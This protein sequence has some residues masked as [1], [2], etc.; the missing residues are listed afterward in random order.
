MAN[1]SITL[2]ELLDRVIELEKRRY[3]LT[4]DYLYQTDYTDGSSSSTI[5]LNKP[6]NEY[7]LILIIHA[8][9]EYSQTS[10]TLID[11]KNALRL[12][13]CINSRHENSIMRFTSPTTISIAYETDGASLT[14]NPIVAVIGIK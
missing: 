13:H 3:E 6:Y 5:T 1:T 9:A 2:D 4:V 7:K 11:T 12:S 8:W 14:N 10:T